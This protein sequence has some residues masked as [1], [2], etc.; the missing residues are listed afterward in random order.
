ML[1]LEVAVIL[2]GILSVV[3]AVAVVAL[4]RQVG[5]LHLRIAPVACAKS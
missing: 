4:I 1:I 5:V 3:T 2:L